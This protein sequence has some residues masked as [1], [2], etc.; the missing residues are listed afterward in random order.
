[1]RI[2]RDRAAYDVHGARLQPVFNEHTQRS[3]VAFVSTHNEWR[4]ARRL[5][6]IRSPSGASRMVPIGSW[7]KQGRTWPFASI[8]TDTHGALH[9]TR[10]NGASPRSAR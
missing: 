8:T 3:H 4:N 6:A 1:A 9:A 10:G 7:K 2:L 5:P